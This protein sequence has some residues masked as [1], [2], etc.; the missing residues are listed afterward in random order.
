MSQEINRIKKVYNSVYKRVANDRQ[1]LWS[2]FSQ[3][4]IFYRQ[5]QEKAYVKLFNQYLTE[6]F[7]KLRVLDVGCGDGGFLC[8][9]RTLGVEPK[10]LYGLDLMD[11][12]IKNAKNFCPSAAHLVCGNGAKLPYKDK[13]FN[14]VSQITTFS[15]VLDRSERLKIAKE[16]IRVMDKNGYLLWYDMRGGRRGNT[17]GLEKKEILVLFPKFKV[18]AIQKIHSPYLAYAAK[19][20]PFWA[21]IFDKL[22]V[23]HKTHY[24]ILMQER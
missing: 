11:Y 17:L 18:I 15:S 8:F 2:P 16:M 10:N 3:V 1:Y 22:F 23:F 6:D 21:V 9:L 12:R 4:S 20:S 24:L 19:I 7:A 5:A 14:L 13:Y